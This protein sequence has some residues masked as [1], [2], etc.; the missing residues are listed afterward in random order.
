MTL[1][2]TAEAL[3]PPNYTWFILR[4]NDSVELNETGPILAFDSLEISD[5]GVYSCQ[6]ENQLGI[7]NSSSA[8]LNIE[9]EA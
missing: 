9:G 2:C 1:N 4:G 8:V 7:A 3:P 6:A 5:R